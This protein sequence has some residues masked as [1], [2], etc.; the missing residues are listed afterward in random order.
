V[1]PIEAVREGAA[2]PRTRLAP[3]RPYVAGIAAVLGVAG[4]ANGVFAGGSATTIL[5]SMG[6]GTVLLFVGVAMVASH[7]IRPIAAVVGAP[8]RSLGGAPG[9]LAAENSVRNPGRTASTAAALMIGL[10]LV[11]FVAVLGSGMRSAFGDTLN[12]QLRGDYVV[13]VNTDADVALLAKSAGAEIANT[14]GV[15]IASSVRSDKAQIRG[16]DTGV[17]G[18]E[19]RTITRVYRFD[20][21]QGSDRVLSRLRDGAL[22]DEDY[23]KKNGLDVGSP[24]QLRT[25]SGARAT[26]R[27][28]AIYKVGVEQLLSGVVIPQ[29]AFDAVFPRPRD[30]YT[31][32]KARSGGD[33]GASLRRTLARYPDAQLKT[34]AAFI[35][36]DQKDLDTSLMLF[37]VLLALSVVV[38]LFGMVN[39]MILSVFERTRE[40]GMLRAIGMSRRQ[41]RR[42]V[43]HESVITALIGAA[44][45]LPLGV[46]L[47]AIVTRGLADQGV[48]FHLPVTPLLVFTA[49]A[50]L[51]GI[52][53]SIP[54]ARRASRLDV[55]HALQYE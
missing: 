10:A 44:L 22:V 52:L 42:M 16:N 41:A 45:G 47:A 46:F 51:A 24:L 21:K 6:A 53:A 31:F 29:A 2:L 55:L 19:P 33:A 50:A 5:T 25:S 34:T 3:L 38:S 12:K 13:S 48:A 54:P 18:V 39:T 7:L 30:V 17:V 9:R 11:T 27:V 4:I 35:K 26:F 36:A 1:S 32:V 15:A 43:R 14:S 23:A 20:W 8:A 28:R 37:Y 49:V 40:L